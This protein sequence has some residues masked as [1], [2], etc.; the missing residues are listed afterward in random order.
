[1]LEI[2]L[3]DSSISENDSINLKIDLEAL[4]RFERLKCMIN[5]EIIKFLTKILPLHMMSAINIPAEFFHSSVLSLIIDLVIQLIFA[6]H[7]L[8]FDA[9]ANKTLCDQLSQQL[10]K[11]LATI[12]SKNCPTELHDSF[13]QKL[14]HNVVTRLQITTETAQQMLNSEIISIKQINSVNGL[15]MICKKLSKYQFNSISNELIKKSIFILLLNLFESIREKRL[16][17]WHAVNLSPKIKQYAYQLIGICF[18]F[19][20]TQLNDVIQL[21][22]NPAELIQL[23]DNEHKQPIKI[24]HGEHF[25]NTYRLLI[26][27]YF[28]QTSAEIINCFIEK[29]TNINISY[30]SHMFINFSIYLYKYRQHDINC[31]RQIVQNLLHHWPTILERAQVQTINEIIANET[32]TFILIELMSHIAVI[33]PFEKNEI[34]HLTSGLCDWILSIISSNS[35]TIELKS[36]AIFLIPCLIGPN[37]TEHQAISDALQCIQLQYFPLYS[38]EF[39]SGSLKR[40]AFVKIFKKILN[41]MTASKSLILLKFIINVSVSDDK[42]ILESS[43]QLALEKFLQHQHQMCPLQ[44]P[45]DMACNESLEPSLRKSIV[46]RFL[47]PMIKH[48]G[49]DGVVKLYAKNI[50]KIDGMTGANYGIGSA[51]WMVEHALVN[52]IIGFQLME[53]LYATVDKD[54]LH[55]IDCSIGVALLGMFFIILF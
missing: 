8:G 24:M 42:H 45:F 12:Q 13:V 50:K 5:I 6:P 44:I 23:I 32:I 28:L 2:L 53:M 17:N 47:I 33:C 3:S 35:I 48:C 38:N 41:A 30:I 51:G 25:L 27:D 15:T 40:S 16:N 37:D 20:D 9:M 10:E 11:F 19:G 36:K 55:R 18:Q 46:G 22:L 21:V 31:L 54:L 52:R 14:S 26:F 39:I 1:M 29:L 49:T 7:E 43:I 34:V 4:N